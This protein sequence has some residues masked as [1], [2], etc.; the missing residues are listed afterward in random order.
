MGRAP[1]V[2]PDNRSQYSKPSYKSTKTTFVILIGISKKTKRQIKY[3]KILNSQFC[4]YK[5]EIMYL[6]AFPSST[7]S[8]ISIPISKYINHYYTQHRNLY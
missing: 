6:I 1:P 3:P 2:V 4:F 5:N 7:D 8:Y